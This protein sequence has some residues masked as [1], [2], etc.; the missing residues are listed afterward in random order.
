MKASSGHQRASLAEGS[1]NGRA[2]ILRIIDVKWTPSLK[3]RFETMMQ[4][5]RYNLNSGPGNACAEALALSVIYRRGNVLAERDLVTYSGL[6]MQAGTPDGAITLSSGGLCAC[7]VVRARA[8][9]GYGGVRTLLRTLLVKI[10]KSLR[11]LVNCGMGEKVCSFIIAAWIPN[12]LSTKALASLRSLLGRIVGID[13]RFEIVLLVSPKNVR[14]LIFPDR[15]GSNEDL[16]DSGSNVDNQALEKLLQ[17]IEAHNNYWKQ[18]NSA[19][20]LDDECKFGIL[21]SLL[22]L[23]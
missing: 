13:H 17:G 22:W 7:Q 3:N 16:T 23:E 1:S 9:S 19:K 20:I 11:W 21:E 8:P 15:F 10:Y 4:A 2:L 12:R 14:N 18:Q 5:T 6:D